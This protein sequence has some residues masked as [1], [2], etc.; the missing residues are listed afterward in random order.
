[1]PVGHFQ[2]VIIKM[3]GFHN[4]YPIKFHYCCHFI[5]GNSYRWVFVFFLHPWMSNYIK[6]FFYSLQA[7][8]YFL[9]LKCILFCAFHNVTTTYNSKQ[10][11]LLVSL[12]HLFREAYYSVQFP[13]QQLKWKCND[14]SCHYLWEWMDVLKIVF[15]INC[16]HFFVPFWIKKDRVSDNK[17]PTQWCRSVPPVEIGLFS[18]CPDSLSDKRPSASPSHRTKCVQMHVVGLLLQDVSCTIQ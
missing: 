12:L 5:C 17:S 3:S 1:M 10:N 13:R 2:C 16:L 11:Q 7:V 6:L 14:M 4:S 15:F 8:S 9:H 18:I